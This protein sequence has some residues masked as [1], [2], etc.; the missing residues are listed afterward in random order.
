MST[1]EI[2]GRLAAL[3]KELT[4]RDLDGFVIPLT[5]EHQSE[6]VADGAQRLA[7][8]SGFTGSFGSAIVLMDKAAAFTDGRYTLQIE[9]QVDGEL[10]A[11]CHFQQQPPKDWLTENLTDGMRIGY[12]PFLH[13]IGWVT[14][15]S[16]ALA[17]KGAELVPVD[18]NPVDAAWLDRP[19]EPNQPVVIHGFEFTGEE[20]ADK[21]ARLAEE[22]RRQGADAV[23]LTAL[24]SIAWLF[25]IRSADVLHTPV[26]LAYAVLGND[27]RGLL[28]LDESKATDELRQ[29]LGTEV[30][31]RPKSGFI[32]YLRGLQGRTI[33]ADPATASAAVFAALEEAGARILRTPDPCSLPKAIKN[34]TEL[35]GARRAH[36]R[37]GV[38]V[39][40]FLKWFAEEA[41]KGGLSEISAADKLLWFRKQGE[42]YRDTSFST[43]SGAGP[44]GAII[45]YRASQETNRQIE[46]GIV[47]LIDSGAQYLDG[48]TDIT[49][50]LAVGEVGD[51]PKDRFTRVLKGHIAL[52]SAIFPE[53]TT[54]SQ[55]DALARQPLWQAGLDY[56]HGTGHGVGSY[57]AVHEG[58]GRIS[59]WPNTIALRPG[60]IFS[61]EPGYYKA[62][63][64][65]I[66]IEN[67]VYVRQ[68]DSPGERQMLG[69]REL[70]LA[71][72]DRNLIAL[73]L[74]EDRELD[75]L[76]SYHARVREEIAP[77][78]DGAE[79]EWLVSQ[80]E[81]ISR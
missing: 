1:K 44:N 12:D 58:P 70:T 32:D 56:D 2:K 80:T 81:A 62:G 18:S 59:P 63:A 75:W 26:S 48:T 11:R 79:R 15:F 54:G 50:T 17:F 47:Y 76:N 73:P 38:A 49:R 29:G 10:F 33:V 65:G 43:I 27:G 61:N 14:E 52:G 41:P 19:G 51:E 3:R 74:L 64:Y 72:I 20:S 23:I 66:R 9:A 28:F 77:H 45:H 78:L 46:P 42:H 71:P 4:A 6:Y 53:G 55:L 25:N 39:S 8:I 37:D 67:L 5:D 13:T 40:R 7:W 60:M 30:T 69:F 21:R 34:E 16:D 57:L 31:I 35:E 68:V 22:L 24:D 36:V